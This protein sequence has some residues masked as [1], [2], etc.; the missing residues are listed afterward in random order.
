MPTR[1]FVDASDT[2]PLHW[3]PA[4]PLYPTLLPTY[5]SHPSNNTRARSDPHLHISLPPLHQGRTLIHTHIENVGHFHGNVF[6]MVQQQ[7]L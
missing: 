3:P 1:Q 4:W 2:A 5:P 6:E 7:D